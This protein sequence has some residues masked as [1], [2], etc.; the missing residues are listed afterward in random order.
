MTRPLVHLRSRVSP[1]VLVCC[2]MDHEIVKKCS[3]VVADFVVIKVL[4]LVILE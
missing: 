3:A 1:N 2:E 4:V